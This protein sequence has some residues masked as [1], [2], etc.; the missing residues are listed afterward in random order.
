MW[1][2]EAEMSG[3][4]DVAAAEAGQPVSQLAV[5]VGCENFDLHLDPGGMGE[6]RPWVS[7]ERR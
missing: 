3:V 1:A 4:H 7:Q 2:L 5:Q 6:R